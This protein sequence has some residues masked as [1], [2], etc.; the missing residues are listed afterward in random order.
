MA[1]ERMR[2][3]KSTWSR[4]RFSDLLT[5]PL[6]SVSA[7]SYNI[8]VN[9]THPLLFFFQKTSFENLLG[10]FGDSWEEA[11]DLLLSATVC[12]LQQSLMEPVWV[13]DPGNWV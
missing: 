7:P 8:A 10:G 2:S 4:E 9:K 13:A 3:S 11:T 1:E 12:L 5:F 6:V